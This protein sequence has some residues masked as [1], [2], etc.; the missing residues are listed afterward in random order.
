L[1]EREYESGEMC[2]ECLRVSSLAASPELGAELAG[3]GQVLVAL[4]RG[5]VPAELLVREHLVIAHAEPLSR[6]QAVAPGLPSP[7]GPLVDPGQES[8]A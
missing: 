2:G 6:G 1:L 4:G 5:A 3:A 8:L 7:Y